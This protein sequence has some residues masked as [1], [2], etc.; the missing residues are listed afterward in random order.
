M[1]CL[2]L[3]LVA[4][5]SRAVEEPGPSNSAI[6]SESIYLLE[7]RI[8]PDW[9]HNTDG[10]FFA[11][12]LAGNYER[13]RATA[14]EVVSNE[15]AESITI[16]NAQEDDGALIKFPEPTGLVECYFA[17]ITTGKNV[18][19]YLYFTYEKTEDEANIGVV[20][21]IGGWSKDLD[22]FNYGPRTYRDAGSFVSD[23]QEISAR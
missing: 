21:M 16:E 23:V 13:L 15:F 14:A 2:V 4:S 17:Y 12:L 19:T 10:A 7:H 18:G 11:D 1:L 6:A 8:I 5:G 20:G 9:T 3:V 22:H